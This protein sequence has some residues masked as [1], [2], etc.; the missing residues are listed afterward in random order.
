M[1]T[2][3]ARAV[4]SSTSARGQTS[5]IIADHRSRGTRRIGRAAAVRALG[6]P[7]ADD[8]IAEALSIV[9][10][11]TDQPEAAAVVT[12][13]AQ[14]VGLLDLAWTADSELL[15]PRLAETAAGR[16]VPGGASRPG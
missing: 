8:D 14:L 4:I 6:A 3:T 10:V 9:G 5:L 12:R 16:D 13:L 2:L 1:R 7:D 15:V 11:A